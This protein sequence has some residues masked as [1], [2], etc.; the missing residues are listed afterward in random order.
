V[1]YERKSTH[2]I[3]YTQD[4]IRKESSLRRTKYV[5]KTQDKLRNSSA[6]RMTKYALLFPSTTKT[7]AIRLRRRIFVVRSPEKAEVK[8]DFH[9]A[10][11]AHTGLSE[12]FKKLKSKLNLEWPI[13]E[14]IWAGT[15]I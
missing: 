2:G 15:C 13:I 11:K 9:H 14:T 6:T 3:C 10:N 5:T 1:P 4:K 7:R 8:S 12:V